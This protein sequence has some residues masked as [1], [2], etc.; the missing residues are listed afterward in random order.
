L[1]IDAGADHGRAGEFEEFRVVV[2]QPD[3]LATQIRKAFDG[4]ALWNREGPVLRAHEA[5]EGP[6]R[7]GVLRASGV[8]TMFTNVMSPCPAIT[9]STASFGAS[10]TRRGHRGL[11]PR[12]SLGR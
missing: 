8:K 11:L 3:R 1:W 12:H 2:M 9:P 6:Q 10:A 5:V 7:N 4:T